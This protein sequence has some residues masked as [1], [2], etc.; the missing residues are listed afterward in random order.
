MH[1]ALLVALSGVFWFAIGASGLADEL[2]KKIT[3]DIADRIT[4]VLRDT[5]RREKN[6]DYEKAELHKSTAVCT[7]WSTW[8][9]V[10]GEVRPRHPIFGSALFFSYG[11]AYGYKSS[12]IARN[13]ALE[14]CE[15]NRPKHTCD[16]C[17]TLDVDDQAQIQIPDNELARL[18][19]MKAAFEKYQVI[20]AEIESVAHLG[21]PRSL[22]VEAPPPNRSKDGSITIAPIDCDRN[23]GCLCWQSF[24]NDLQRVDPEQVESYVRRLNALAQLPFFSCGD[25][26]SVNDDREL[27][28]PVCRYI[29]HIHTS[30]TIKGMLTKSFRGIELKEGWYESAVRVNKSYFP[31]DRP[32][33]G[34]RLIFAKSSDDEYYI[35]LARQNGQRNWACAVGVRLQYQAFNLARCQ[36]QNKSACGERAVSSFLP[37]I[38]AKLSA[39]PLRADLVQ[40]VGNRGQLE[41]ERKGESEVLGKPWFEWSNYFLTWWGSGSSALVYL[42]DQD[43]GRIGNSDDIQISLSG[44]NEISLDPDRYYELAKGTRATAFEKATRSAFLGALTETCA[45]LKGKMELEICHIGDEALQ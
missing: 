19:N 26:K 12:D 27:S 30:H 16:V 36:T 31:V 32:L 1:I 21:P 23:Y 13:A 17:V 7:M 29:K 2:G 5:L 11:Y 33:S 20:L 28:F 44:N 42:V 3:K 45:S 24:R 18:S 38:K 40:N 25:V 8:E 9:Y 37:A 39:A 35:G 34:A 14:S 4:G 41:F 22:D 15:E 43:Q 10:D 6:L